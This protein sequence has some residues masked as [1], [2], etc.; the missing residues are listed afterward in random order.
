MKA[1]NKLDQ[2]GGPLPARLQIFHKILI[3][4]INRE[5][6][7]TIDDSVYHIE[8]NMLGMFKV[9]ELKCKSFMFAFHLP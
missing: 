9:S 2:L 6:T 3:V 5:T 7:L 1:K 8:L 4:N